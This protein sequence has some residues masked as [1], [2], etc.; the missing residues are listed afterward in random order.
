MRLPVT[1]ENHQHLMLD[2]SGDAGGTSTEWLHWTFG[3]TL[4]K[5]ELICNGADGFINDY[6]RARSLLAL[7]YPGT[8]ILRKGFADRLWKIHQI[9]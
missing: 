2:S 5:W 8:S 1:G 9:S 6:T 4:T 3:R 7:R